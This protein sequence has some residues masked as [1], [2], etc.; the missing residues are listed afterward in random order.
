MLGIPTTAKAWNQT[1]DIKSGASLRKKLTCEE[2]PTR[3]RLTAIYRQEII[4]VVTLFTSQ[5][6]ATL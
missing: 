4:Q 5:R 6:A 1:Y 2:N 3:K